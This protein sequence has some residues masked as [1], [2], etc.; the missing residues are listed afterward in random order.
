VT[1]STEKMALGYRVDRRL[2]WVWAWVLAVA[3]A[4]FAGQPPNPP[5]P[6]DKD[7]GSV[8]PA[9]GA[10][11]TTTGSVRTTEGEPI[12]GATVRLTDTATNKVWVSWTDESGKFEFPAAAGLYRAEAS[13][14]GFIQASQDVQLPAPIDKPIALVLRVATLAEIAAPSR[15]GYP[16]RG[17]GQGAAQNGQASSADRSRAYAPGARGQFGGNGGRVELPP[18]IANA[19][20]QGLGGGFEQ[21]DV[22][23]ESATGGREAGDMNEPAGAAS[24]SGPSASSADSFLI[25]GTVGQGLPASGPGEFG[26]R[27]PGEI[28]PGGLAPGGPSGG[29]PV[30]GFGPGALGSVPAPGGFGGGRGGFPGG[31]GGARLFRQAANRIRFSFYDRYSNAAFDAKPYSITGNEFPKVRTYD[32]RLGGNLGGPLKIPHIYNG[33]DHTYVFV[34]FQHESQEAGVSSFSTVPTQAERSGNFCGLGI[35]LYDPSSDL[36]GPRSPLGNGCQIPTINRAAA[37]LLAYYPLPNVPGQVAQNYLLQAKTPVTSDLVNLH[38]LHTINSKYNVDGGYNFTSQ[39]KDTVGNFPDIGG[40][41]STRSQNVSL[42]LSHNWSAHLVEN[43][44]LNWSRNRIQVQSNNSFTNNVAGILGIGGIATDPID[45]GVPAIQF[46]SLS[47]LNDPIPS[48]VR[49]QTLRFSDSWTLVHAKH[50]MSFGGEIRRIQLNTDS[51]PNP[52]GRFVFT[53]VMTTQLN[54]NGQPSARQTPQTEP[55]FEFADFLL[56]LPYNTSVQFGNPNIY[57]RS[58]GFI[59]YAQD[60]WRINKRFTFQYGVRY[61][62]VT[63]PVES[64]DHLANLDLN[65]ATTAVAVVTPGEVGPYRGAYPRALIHGEYGNWAPRIGFAWQPNIKPKTVVRAGYS[66][67]YNVSVYNTLA[68]KYLAYQPPFDKSQNWYTDPTQVLT[69]QAGF[70]GQA[71]SNAKILNTAGVNPN[72][73][74]GYAQIWMLG[75]ET[76]FTQNWILD[77]TYTGTKGTDLDLLRAPNR[78]PLGTSQLG[79]QKS[80]R[81][82]YATSFYYDQSGANSIFNALQARVV[83]RFT[84]GVFLQGAYTFAKS[85]DNASSI[86]GSTPVVVQQDGNFAAERGLSS[87]DIRHQFRLS[88]TYQLPFGQKSRWANHGWSEHVFGNWRILDIVTWQ[89]GTPVTVLLGGRAA[90]NSGTGSNFSER[91]NQVGNPNLGIC[92]GSSL[93]YFHTAAFAAPAPGQYGDERRGAVEGPCTFS[94]NLSLSKSFRFG[95]EQRHTVNASWEIQNLTNTPNFNGVGNL[96]GS[97][98]FGRVTGAGSMRTM[99]IMIRLN[100]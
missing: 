80:L 26:P 13:Q 84:H 28:A 59:G 71:Q 57:L 99:D 70:P 91:A 79:T 97:S 3:M 35:T 94:W 77:L 7:S 2:L 67:F 95:P 55:Y 62:S 52:R 19:N 1:S 47:S 65:S 15:P 98:T 25:Q 44:Q 48:L 16:N 10:T 66:I 90:N 50:T 63:P 8:A 82:P 76:S 46:T 69:L 81:I 75:T 42:G 49:N 64:Y 73:E 14:L 37:G 32:D 45:Y 4:S 85:L 93:G 72:Y 61:Q 12:P 22:V 29:G 5:R 74:R 96:L 60:D 31:G 51:D 58:W 9:S 89:T 83:H 24:S 6:Q 56:G 11:A 30:Q 20:R 68:E 21:T 100:L 41:Q 92:G 39:R 54:P 87:F 88:S 17:R 40:H 27:G 36:S 34:N 33:A 86:G 18:G 53:G 43:T 78:A 23:G 38:V